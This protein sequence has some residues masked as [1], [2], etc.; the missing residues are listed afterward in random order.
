MAEDKIAPAPPSEEPV[1]DATSTKTDKATTVPES[2]TTAGVSMKDTLPVSADKAADATP[3]LDAGS[4]GADTSADA[5]P[6]VP[7]EA[8]EATSSN[9]PTGDT[10]KPVASTPA[11]KSKSRR[12][13]SSMGSVKKTLSKKQSK[14]KILH[15][16]AKPGDLFIHKLKGYPAWPVIICDEE[17]LSADLL[18][19]RP[20]SALRQD[21]TYRED[22]ADGGKNIA[23]RTFPVLYLASYEFGW[24]PNQDLQDLD[25]ETARAASEKMRNGALKL[26]HELAAEGNSLDFYKRVLQEEEERRQQM[27]A[28]QDAKKSK[29]NKAVADDDDVAMVD[30]DLPEDDDKEKDSAQSRKRKAEDDAPAPQ[31]SDSVKKP[32]IKLTS[33]PKNANGA[34]T[35]K[36]SKENA[37][38]PSKSKPRKSTKSSDSRVEND[39]PK[40][41]ELSPEEKRARKEKEVLFLRHKLQRGLLT[42]DQEPKEEEMRTMSEYITKLEGFPDLEVAIIRIT[43]INKVLKAI[44]KLESIPKEEEFHFKARS[45]VLLEKWTKII[46]SEASATPAPVN[47]TANGTPAESNGNQDEKV[48]PNG[49]HKNTEDTPA[50]ADEATKLDGKAS[51]TDESANKSTAEPEETPAA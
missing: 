16:D 22:Y 33:A 6:S 45:Q 9:K 51:K 24:A 49:A 46:A 1:T 30:A 48:A 25:P 5:E 11:D 35:P 36:S 3:N 18:K 2:S 19:S 40:E 42:R 37:S 28:A 26:A 50:A 27:K 7:G 20:V 17:M 10:P 13:S 41:P 23:G 47:G 8:P 39:A 29:K 31:R 15:T 44:L 34:A 4:K 14:A 32:K 43:K 38:K 21:G 12:K